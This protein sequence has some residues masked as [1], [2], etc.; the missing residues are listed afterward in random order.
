MEGLPCLEEDLSCLAEDLPNPD[1]ETGCFP[2]VSRFEQV[3][4]ASPI[5]DLV[6]VVSD[7]VEAVSLVVAVGVVAEAEAASV[8]VVGFVGMVA[9]ASL[10]AAAV[11][12]VSGPFPVA[13]ADYLAFPILLEPAASLG[14][15]LACPILALVPEVAKS[16]A[17]L[18]PHPIVGCSAAHDLRTLRA[19]D[20]F[21]KRKQRG[22]N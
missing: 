10:R 11:H 3:L 14:L 2:L 1:D 5:L 16:L 22:Q 6:M 17:E 15:C 20:P 12:L 9:V 8:V 4:W 7:L 18:D 21:E 13:E 19:L